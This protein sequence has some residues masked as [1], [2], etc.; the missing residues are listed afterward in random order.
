MIRLAMLCTVAA[1]LASCSEEVNV[2]VPA[3]VSMTEEA[4]GHYCQMIVLE[5]AGPKA[6]VHLAGT[7]EPLWFSQVRDA[8]VFDRLPEETAEV[9]AIYVNDMGAAKSWDEPGI[10]NWIA[11]DQAVY[12]IGSAMRGGMGAPEFV[13]FLDAEAAKRFA[14]DHGGTLVTYPDISDEMVL[15]P[16]EVDLEAHGG[17]ALDHAVPEADG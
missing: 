12:V 8:F 1:L 15:A 5:H 14:A 4:V 10:E 2:T 7:A 3:P 11:A 13:P 17:H 16:V 9:A 6:Q